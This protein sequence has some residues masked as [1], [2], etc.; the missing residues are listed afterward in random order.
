MLPEENP[1]DNPQEFLRRLRAAKD[2]DEDATGALSAE[3]QGDAGTR[4]DAAASSHMARVPAKSKLPGAA[5]SP[6]S[7]PRSPGVPRASAGPPSGASRRPGTVAS[8]L[9]AR[10]AGS[11]RRRRGPASSRDAREPPAGADGEGSAFL[12]IREASDAVDGS[13]EALGSLR[14]FADAMAMRADLARTRARLAS[15]ESA[16]SVA[17][18]RVEDLRDRLAQLEDMLARERSTHRDEG[19]ELAEAHDKLRAM[20]TTWFGPGQFREMERRAV[21]AEARAAALEK[22]LAKEKNAALV[23]GRMAREAEGKLEEVEMSAA[24]GGQA[25]ELYAR[26]LEAEREENRALRATV[27]DLKRRVQSESTMAQVQGANER[28]D[29]AERDKRYAEFL[30][31]KVEG[32]VRR[33]DGRGG[34]GGEGTTPRLEITN[35]SARARG[36]LCCLGRLLKRSHVLSATARSQRAPV[37][38]GTLSSR[39]T[40][41]RSPSPSMP[42][43]ISYHIMHR[44]SAR[45][46]SRCGTSYAPRRGGTGSTGTLRGRCRRRWSRRGG[47]GMRG[48]GL[49]KRARGRR[50]GERNS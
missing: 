11:P 24:A 25:S 22:R 34:E 31:E 46:R 43:T 47:G 19:K 33:G 13:D 49:W 41:I 45:R 48:R 10:R 29:R 40:S 12:E 42:H 8:E 26:Q 2:G 7:R 39:A 20:Q 37:S 4:P 17:A 35:S 38:I 3:E 36:R 27:A 50:R 15:V 1:F 14:R 23:A 28:A 9:L 32:E 6:R 21:E 44:S 16:S 18:H 5:A 30:K